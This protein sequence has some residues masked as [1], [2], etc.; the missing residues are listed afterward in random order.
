MLS[1]HRFLAL[2]CIFGLVFGG[3]AGVLL[4]AICGFAIDRMRGDLESEV[5]A[6]RLLEAATQDAEP[7]AKYDAAFSVGAVV[8]AA[9]L[10]KSDGQVSKAE[11][12][13]FHEVFY[14]PNEAYGA[15]ARLFN[16]AVRMRES[17]FAYAE[18][19]ARLFAD[20]PRLLHEL[21]QGLVRI[22]AASDGVGSQEWRFLSE[23]ARIFA[24]P[25]AHLKDLIEQEL[26]QQVA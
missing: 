5:H 11:I 23:V 6:E 15:T 22:A 1:K 10:A 17:A 12:Q 26:G 20:E 14:V 7:E 9:K 13:A 19:L 24:I 16:R 18:Q 4:G 2:G 25:E 8:L 21:L 3:G